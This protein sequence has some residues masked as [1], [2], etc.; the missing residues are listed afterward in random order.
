MIVFHIF[1]IPRGRTVFS[2]E[3]CGYGI[4][5]DLFHL[6]GDMIITRQTLSCLRTRALNH[7]RPKG[8]WESLRSGQSGS[9]SRRGAAGK[10][11]S[12]PPPPCPSHVVVIVVV[13]VTLAWPLWLRSFWRNHRQGAVRASGVRMAGSSGQE[14]RDIPGFCPYRLR[15][16]EEQLMPILAKHTEAGP[17]TAGRSPAI[18][19]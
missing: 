18:A 15:R 6:P 9:S 16:V 14:P 19:R 12:S 2:I 10:I 7:F 5:F 3:P 17:A 8:W 4:K 11:S 1:P 13:V